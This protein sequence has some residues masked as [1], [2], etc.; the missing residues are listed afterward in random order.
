MQSKKELGGRRWGGKSL[1]CG[2]FLA[3]LALRI[4]SAILE[5]QWQLMGCLGEHSWPAES[6]SMDLCSVQF[7][8][9]WTADG[10]QW[11]VCS[12][13]HGGYCSWVQPEHPIHYT[14]TEWGSQCFHLSFHLFMSD[15]PSYW[16]LFLRKV[17]NATVS[18][19]VP[20]SFSVTF[21]GHKNNYL[22]FSHS[23]SPWLLSP[24]KEWLVFN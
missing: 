17:C 5:V 19:S 21:T 23:S 4:L 13:Q 8:P 3:G 22:L 18:V 15:A 14:V 16:D 9:C 1:G 6:S 11:A 12:G 10:Q 2:T 24:K 20:I 7:W